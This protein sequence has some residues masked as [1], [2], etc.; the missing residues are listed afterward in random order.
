MTLVGLTSFLG[1]LAAAND[2]TLFTIGLSLRWIGFALFIHFVLAF[3]AGRLEGTAA[4]ATVAGTWA[5]VTLGQLASLLVSPGSDFCED[6]AGCPPNR[7]LVDDSATGETVVN[8]VVQLGAIAVAAAAVAILWR[9]FDR[10][11]PAVRRTLAPV[12]VTATVVI[13]SI[14]LVLAGRWLSD[15]LATALEWVTIVGLLSVPLAS[16]L[17][18]L[19]R[20]LSRAAVSE[21]VVEIGRDRSPDGIESALRRVLHDPTLTLARWDE[22]RRAVRRP[23]RR[24]GRPRRRE[25]EPTDDAR[26]A[27]RDTRSRR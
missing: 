25:P 10:A 14:L 17:G 16:L 26:G 11:T 13:A 3:P 7:L 27:R 21:L 8:L 5:L 18:L 22:E 20:K 12:Y 9:R 23:R 15:P 24:P 19:E 6:G 4:R 1:A 2:G